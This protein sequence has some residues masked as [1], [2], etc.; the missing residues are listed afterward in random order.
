MYLKGGHE[1]VQNVNDLFT[2][3]WTLL[4]ASGAD[5]MYLKGSHQLPVVQNVYEFFTTGWT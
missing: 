2:T 4:S 1:F 5:F 3:G